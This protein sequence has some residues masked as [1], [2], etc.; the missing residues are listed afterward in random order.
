[1]LRSYMDAQGDVDEEGAEQK[2]EEEDEDG[3]Q[4]GWTAEDSVEK[5][6]ELIDEFEKQI[7]KNE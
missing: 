7:S 2:Q 5:M 3:D 4:E 1:M 6:T